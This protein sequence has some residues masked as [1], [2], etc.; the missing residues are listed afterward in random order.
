MLL[1]RRYYY[2]FVLYDGY[3]RGMQ[4]RS[5]LRLLATSRKVEGSVLDEVIAFL[6][7]D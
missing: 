4:E 2:N 6:Q 7:F 1:I 5:W 3:L